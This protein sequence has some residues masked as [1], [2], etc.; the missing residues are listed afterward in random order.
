MEASAFLKLCQHSEHAGVNS[1]GVIKGVSDLGDENKPRDSVVYNDALEAT[2]GVVKD[3]ISFYFRSMT[4][5]P[6]E[7]M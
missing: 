3:W 5:E 2:G 1:L 4:W 6:D 7:S